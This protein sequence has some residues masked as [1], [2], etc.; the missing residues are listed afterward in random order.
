MEALKID[1]EYDEVLRLHAQGQGHHAGRGRHPQSS[2]AYT[3][4]HRRGPPGCIGPRQRAAGAARLGAGVGDTVEIFTS[5]EARAR[6]VDWLQFVHTPRPATRTWSNAR[7]N[8]G[9]VKPL[10]T[11]HEELAQGKSAREGLQALQRLGVVGPRSQASAGRDALRR[12]RGAPRRD[13]REASVSQPKSRRAAVAGNC[14]AATSSWIT[15]GAT[16]RAGA[17][18]SPT[19]G[20]PGVHVEGLDDVMVQLSGAAPGARRPRSSASSA[21]AGACR[22]TGP[23]TPTPPAWVQRRAHRARV[24]PGPAALVVSVEVEALDRSN[25]LR[26]VAQVLSDHHVNIISCSSTP[27]T[28]GVGH[29]TSTSSSPTPATSSGSFWAVSKQ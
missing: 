6:A 12:R 4:A 8:D 17:A 26:D 14:A 15:N 20:A 25:L 16:P 2:L 10:D 18:V 21:G 27:R 28:S 5:K 1:L 23:T 19:G 24:G 11:G 22:S 13:R 7:G 3:D 9:Y 29:S